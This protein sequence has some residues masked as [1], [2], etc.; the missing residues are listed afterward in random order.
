MLR[1][2]KA[3]LLITTGKLD[4]GAQVAT[5]FI[6]TKLVMVLKLSKSAGASY[7]LTLITPLISI[8]RIINTV[9]IH[10]TVL[11]YPLHVV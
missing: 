1:K 11:V 9:T 7:R 5:N 2:T 6:Q 4:F 3:F 10:F 8:I